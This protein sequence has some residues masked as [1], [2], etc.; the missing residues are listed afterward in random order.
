[1]GSRFL[2][3]IQESN[4]NQENSPAKVWYQ[5][6]EPLKLT[7]SLANFSDVG[8]GTSPLQ[9]AGSCQGMGD[10]KFDNTSLYA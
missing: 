4:R 2:R 5:S 10:F 8:A 9:C 6:I 7:G 3:L 1:M